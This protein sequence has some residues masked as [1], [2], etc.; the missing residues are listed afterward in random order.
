MKQH[1]SER[2]MKRAAV[3]VLSAVEPLGALAPAPRRPQPLPQ[4]AL[5][6]AWVWAA[7]GAVIRAAE[8]MRRSC[9][10]PWTFVYESARRHGGGGFEFRGTL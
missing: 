9:S 5:R 2:K 7:A 1:T 3:C 4:I 8:G 6:T 10:S